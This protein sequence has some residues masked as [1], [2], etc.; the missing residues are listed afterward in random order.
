[1]KEMD[2]SRLARSFLFRASLSLFVVLKYL[3]NFHE[4]SRRENVQIKREDGLGFSL[5]HAIG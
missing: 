2:L 3:L 1:M 4:D 5:P